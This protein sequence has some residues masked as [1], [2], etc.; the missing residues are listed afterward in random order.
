MQPAAQQQTQIQQSA[1]SQ[2]T[3]QT[4]VVT[5]IVQQSNIPMVR[6]N[7][8]PNIQTSSQNQPIVKSETVEVQGTNNNINIINSNNNSSNES[9][10][11]LKKIDTNLSSVVNEDDTKKS[12]IDNNISKPASTLNNNSNEEGSNENMQKSETENEDNN[13]KTSSDLDFSHEKIAQSNTKVSVVS[14]TGKTFI[15]LSNNTFGIA[16]MKSSQNTNINAQNIVVS[17]SSNQPHFM[18]TL[19]FGTSR[20]SIFV[21]NVIA[22][23]L[24]SSPQFTVHQY[25]LHSNVNGPAPNVTVNPNGHFNT[26]PNSTIRA[27]GTPNHFRLLFQQTPNINFN[28]IGNNNGNNNNNSS[29]Q[30]NPGNNGQATVRTTQSPILEASLQAINKIANN[31]I[32]QN[33][34]II[35][36]NR[37]ITNKLMSPKTIAIQNSQ[38]PQKVM[39]TILMDQTMIRPPHFSGLGITQFNQANADQHIRVLTPSEIMR[40]LPSLANTAPCFSTA[41]QI[42]DNK[43]LKSSE[44]ISKLNNNQQ[45]LIN[46]KQEHQKLQET[47]AVVDRSDCENQSFDIS[48]NNNNHLLLEPS[49]NS[50]N[51]PTSNVTCDNTIKKILITTSTTNTT[52]AS[53]IAQMVRKDTKRKK[54]KINFVFYLSTNIMYIN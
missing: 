3:S 28:I 53:S 42:P 47:T 19:T 49:L 5:Q 32:I 4:V 33:S 11:N 36:Q 31:Q 44:E 51:I 21:P 7:S 13:T 48:S 34:N 35:Q 24:T 2:S 17:Q 6:I 50:T 12:V 15:N 25:G 29:I 16:N 23:N 54:I 8:E 38:Q 14:N 18:K 9:S 26:N 27:T 37:I 41:N 39:K 43:I 52:T 40:T 1:N 45:Q 46:L 10:T 30:N 20:G 22:T